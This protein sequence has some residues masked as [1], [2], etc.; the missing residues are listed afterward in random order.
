MV[1]R[2]GT[3]VRIRSVRRHGGRGEE[4]DRYRTAFLDARRGGRDEHARD[5]PEINKSG[6]RLRQKKKNTSVG[7]K[8]LQSR[9]QTGRDRYQ[10][11][12]PIV[13]RI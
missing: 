12:I 3:I 7:Y 8:P 13:S 4:G 10:K 6:M 9:Q 1:G 11:L 5:T 2:W